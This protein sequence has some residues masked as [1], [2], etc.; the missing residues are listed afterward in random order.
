VITGYNTDVEYDGVVYHIQTED[1]GL[2]TPLIL[3]LVYSGGAILASRRTPY[4]DLISSGFD[5]AALSERLDRQ[6]KLICAAIR[7][8]RIGELK[9][10]TE[11]KQSERKEKRT[12]SK[13]RETPS[14]PTSTD[15]ADANDEATATRAGQDAGQ[16]IAEQDNGPGALP[17][18]RFTVSDAV[19]AES[20]LEVTLAEEVELHG[21]DYLTLRVLVSRVSG[22]GPEPVAKARVVLKI[23]GTNFEPASTFSITNKEG[24]ALIFASLPQFQSGRAA[25][26]LRA[27]ADG[28]AA[29]LR[30][31]ILPV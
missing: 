8:G 27:E 13:L 11:R 12:K 9:R 25:I 4:D 29:E 22:N 19:K 1:K 18:D 3:S 15:N 30:R 26:L 14:I 2:Q 28:E 6:H 20:S 31:V 21:G 7:A 10:L 5:E 24:I 17:A 23:L 16:D